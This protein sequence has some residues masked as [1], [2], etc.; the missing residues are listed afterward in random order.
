MLKQKKAQSVLPF[1]ALNL[2]SL[3]IF[4]LVVIALLVM[5][6]NLRFS[7][8]EFDE[9][10]LPL[11]AQKRIISSADCF[12]YEI[13]DMTFDSSGTL[14]SGTRVYP[15][16]LDINK[17]TD[18][19]YF[20]C[21]RKDKYDI[22]TEQYSKKGIWDAEEGVGASFKYSV[23]IFDPVTGTALYK[24]YASDDD[25]NQADVNSI[26]MHTNKKEKSCNKFLTDVCE[27]YGK[28]WDC[29]QYCSDAQKKGPLGI[30]CESGR[31]EY[32]T[33]LFQMTGTAIKPYWDLRTPRVTTLST[34]VIPPSENYETM[35]WYPEGNT[36]TAD[37]YSLLCSDQAN[38][39]RTILPVMINYRDNNPAGNIRPGI[40]IFE[41]CVITGAKY[42]GLSVFEDLVINPEAG[43]DCYS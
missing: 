40:I 29:I 41:S 24:Q 6:K 28:D 33:G 16:I 14:V 42:D 34:Q 17:L 25:P 21:M 43:G 18:V 20:N 31:C 26:V 11:M 4:F 13:K 9:E 3:F 36:D 30:I 2:I 27:H 35:H 8:N 32:Q 37:G 23:T 10:T 7:L 19:D 15:G 1:F 38:T 22:D 12:A 5:A 39:R